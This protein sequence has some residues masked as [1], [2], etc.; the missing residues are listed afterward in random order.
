MAVGYR[1]KMSV[2]AGANRSRG[3]FGIIPLLF[4]ICLNGFGQTGAEAET[5][6]IDV[7]QIKSPRAAMLRSALIPGWGQW[8]NEKRLKAVLVLGAELALIGNAVYFNQLAVRSETEYDSQF[9]RENRRLYLWW[10]AAAHI[11]NVLDALVDAHLSG[12][13]TGPELSGRMAPVSKPVWIGVVWSF[14]RFSVF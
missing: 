4:L 8:Y 14:D 11:L 3:E 6:G 2:C 9:Y 12:F 1:E 5:A 13:D 7:E 10:L